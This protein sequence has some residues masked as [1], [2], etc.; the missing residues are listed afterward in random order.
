MWQSLR[1][2][3]RPR[4]RDNICPLHLH[5]WKWSKRNCRPE[6]ANN[7]WQWMK[8]KNTWKF[9]PKYLSSWI[10]CLALQPYSNTFHLECQFHHN[11]NVSNRIYL[12]SDYRWIHDDLRQGSHD[13]MQSN[14]SETLMYNLCCAEFILENTRYIFVFS[15]I[16]QNWPDMTQV[17]EIYPG[18]RHEL[19][20]STIR[21]M[22]IGNMTVICTYTL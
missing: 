19:V 3:T 21:C 10:G 13:I 22:G 2:Q 14:V 4:P 20:H 7:V 8:L 17:F 1:N 5:G 16:H 11:S 15:I 12:R 18:W 6:S 9:Q